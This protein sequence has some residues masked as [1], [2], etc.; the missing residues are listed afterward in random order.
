MNTAVAPGKLVD[1]TRARIIEAAGE[2]FAE[3]GFEKAT[4]REICARAH[5][6]I[7]AVNYHFRDKLGLYTEVLKAAACNG[8][9]VLEEA[10]AVADPEQALRLFI[11]GMFRRMHEADSPSRY[12]RVMMHELAQP[13]GALDVVVEQMVR[14]NS[15]ILCAIVGQLL[16]RPPDDELTRLSAASVIA[17]VVHHVHAKPVI[18]KLWP[19]LKSS[20]EARERIA[21][22]I[23]NFSLAALHALR[24]SSAP[25]RHSARR[26]K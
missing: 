15:R 2:V 21:D 7:A 5:A 11:H 23:A 10:H 26:S 18:Q 8:R 14:P 19:G 13:T 3:T 17:Q 6:N 4:V 25:A 1:E 24:G 9:A 16:N 12:A 20:P 22:H